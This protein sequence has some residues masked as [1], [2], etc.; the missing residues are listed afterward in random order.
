MND[1]IKH[2]TSYPKKLLRYKKLDVDS[3]QLKVFSDRS[4]NGNEDGYFQVG[5]IILL[6]DNHNNANLL[7]YASIKA[8]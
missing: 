4:F 6:T 8:Q 1:I 3:L 2:L 5:Y 7:D